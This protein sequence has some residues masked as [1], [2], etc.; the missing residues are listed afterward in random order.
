MRACST[1]DWRGVGEGSAAVE[2]EEDGDAGG[3]EEAELVGAGE[4]VPVGLGDAV[5]TG[6]GA[7][8][9]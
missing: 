3:G 9:A 4:A 2:L 5:E 8:S 1:R 6:A 7:R